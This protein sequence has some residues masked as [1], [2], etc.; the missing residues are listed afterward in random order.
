[1]RNKIKVI[2]CIFS[3]LFI[4]TNSTQA[5]KEIVK[6]ENVEE[7]DTGKSSSISYQ[8]TVGERV[9]LYAKKFL[10]VPYRWGGFSPSGFDCSGLVKYVYQKFG[11]SL[12]HNVAAMFGIGKRV[13][14]KLEPGDLVY[15]SGLGHM[16]MYIG[17]GNFIHAPQTGDYVKISD[18]RKRSYYAAYRIVGT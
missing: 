7:K 11:V 8:P 15:F 5:T 18:L 13:E 14:G 10:G 12:P 6:D 2:F 1:M 9:V 4:F 17:N 16:G 3:S